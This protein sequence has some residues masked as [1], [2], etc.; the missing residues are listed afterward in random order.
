MSSPV[1]LGID[2]GTSELKAILLDENGTVLGHAGARLTVSRRQVGW[3][4]QD[5]QDWW[6][7][8]LAVLAQLRLSHPDAYG[9]VRC[10]GLSGQMH[11]AVLLGADDR[12]LYPA[13]LWDD[14][15]AMAQADSLGRDHGDFAAVTGSL[16]MA[17]LTAPKLLWLQQHEP[18]VFRAIDCVLS[19]KDYLRLRLSGERISDVSDAAGTLW[20]DVARRDWY[21]PMLHATGLEPGQMPRLVEG[22]AACTALGTSAALQIGLPAGLTIAGGGG[23]NPVSAVGIGAVNVGDAFATL[24]TSAAIVAITDHAAGNPASA[25]HSFCHALPQRWYTMGAMLA[26]AS[27]LRWVTRL[28]GFADEAALLR[29]IQATLPIEQSVALS[30]PLFLPYL[31]GERTP[32]NDPLLRGGFMGLG[33]DCVPAMLGYAVLEGVGFG[34]LDAM[35]AVLSAGATVERCALVGGGAR[36]EYWAQLL[37]NILEREIFTLQGS[38]LSACIGAAKLGFLAMG[39]GTDLL[40]AG[41]PVKARYFPDPGQGPLLQAR[42]RKFQGLLPAA[43]TLHGQM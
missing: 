43:K 28:L 13:I 23:D 9:R 26:G 10:I 1:S 42:Y 4:E 36:S 40:R 21:P 22:P 32:H 29:Q 20:L 27:C 19:P 17:G 24:G 18:Q 16:P 34:L 41:M 33:H 14:S 8:C 5:P 3:S 2:L 37:A 25:V 12:V 15:R 39:Q 7:A 31:A 6:Q 30:S 38:E 11:G 35:N